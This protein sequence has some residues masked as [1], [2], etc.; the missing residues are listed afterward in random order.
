MSYRQTSGDC[1]H[2]LRS[3]LPHWKIGPHVEQIASYIKTQKGSWEIGEGSV[4][5]KECSVNPLPLAY[6]FVRYLLYCGYE[7]RA[8]SQQIKPSSV[9]L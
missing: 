7:F 1:L 9:K 5:I 2:I 4:K 3:T 8:Y 6:V